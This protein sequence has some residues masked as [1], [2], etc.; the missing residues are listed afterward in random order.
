[1]KEI[2]LSKGHVSF[3]DDEDYERAS[4]FKW[5]ALVKK[6][7]VYGQRTAYINGTKITIKLHRWLLGLTDP[8]IE[9]D[10]EDHDGL[11]NQ[12]YN[13]RVCTGSQNQGNRRKNRYSASK[14]KGL[15]WNAR[16]QV[17]KVQIAGK[18]KGDFKDEVTAAKFYDS[19]ARKHFGKFALCNFN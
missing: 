8:T 5:H 2:P 16:D 1:M 11:N 7:S 17:W 10:H 3:V 4:K 9:V 12:K 19:A 13:L 18:Q 15:S 14:Y 6:R